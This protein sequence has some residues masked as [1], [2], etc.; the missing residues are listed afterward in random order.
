M[1]TTEKKHRANLREIRRL[2]VKIS[3]GLGR[4]AGATLAA[5]DRRMEQDRKLLAK[6]ADEEAEA[7]LNDFN[8]VG[9]RHHY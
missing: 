3:T 2:Q 5:L 4:N 9:S 1:T 8:Y 6:L 7:L